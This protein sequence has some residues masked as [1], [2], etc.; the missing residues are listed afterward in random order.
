MR[1]LEH[2]WQRD[3]DSLARLPEFFTTEQA[4][5]AWN[6]KRVDTTHV[7]IKLL[8]LAGYVELV[9]VRVTTNPS[10]NGES[11]TYTWRKVAI[12]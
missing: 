7:R 6:Y 2:S 3:K 12:Q 8:E 11:R 1:S 10:G 4:R 9:K 5:D